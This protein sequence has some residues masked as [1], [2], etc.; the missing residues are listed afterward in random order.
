MLLGFQTIYI[1]T[2][3]HTRVVGSSALEKSFANEKAKRT[4]GIKYYFVEKAIRAF[5][6]AIPGKGVKFPRAVGTSEKDS[7]GSATGVPKTQ[8]HS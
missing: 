3:T 1:Y 5:S 7:R 8:L 4:F 6:L 2:H